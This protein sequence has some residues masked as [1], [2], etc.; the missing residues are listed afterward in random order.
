MF[1]MSEN[2]PSAVRDRP[3]PWRC[4]ECRE[5]QVYPLATDFEITVKHDGRPYEIQVPGLEIP[6]CRNCGEQVFTSKEDDQITAKL[7]AEIHLLTP[8]EIRSKRQEL[9]LNQEKFADQLGVAKETISRWETGA[10][11]QSRAMDNLLRLYFDS[12][13]ARELLGR[14]FKP[15]QINRF[16]RIKSMEDG[17]QFELNPSRN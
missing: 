4:V 9:G 6:T 10:V 2:K 5:M 12:A 16:T 1:M 13:E 14:G 7:R 11:I 17:R 15:V 3:F 8:E